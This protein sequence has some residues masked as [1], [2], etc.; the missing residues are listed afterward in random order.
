[1][2]KALVFLAAICVGLGTASAMTESEL[3]AELTKTYEINGVQKSVNAKEKVL[4]EEYLDTYEL[5]SDEIDTIYSALNKAKD[6]LIASG[7][8][9]FHD[10][11]KA[12]KNAIIALV[13]EVSASTSIS[14]TISKG[15]LIVYKP[16]T[17][18]VFA[19]LYVDETKNP[20]INGIMPTSATLTVA[21]SG[22]ISM[23]GAGLALKK[24]KENA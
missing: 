8:T 4:I 9:E 12:D 17:T 21:G 19:K 20:S 1:M 15:Q 5:T 18:E 3:K 22:L 24:S 2:K 10:L 6:I 7:K 13:N 23:I 14:A 11:S 16:G